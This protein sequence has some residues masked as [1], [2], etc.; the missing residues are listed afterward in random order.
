[1]WRRGVGEGALLEI[2]V[3]D[4]SIFPSDCWRQYSGAGNWRVRS[5][6]NT[7]INNWWENHKCVYG[8]RS[9]WE[10][11]ITV[12]EKIKRSGERFVHD[13]RWPLEKCLTT[14]DLRI[15]KKGGRGLAPVQSLTDVAAVEVMD[16][17]GKHER[18]DSEIV[19]PLQL[20]MQKIHNKDC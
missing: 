10:Y 18:R 6:Q 12:L 11:A 14:A 9:H 4:R 7:F 1:M 8:G 15:E 3:G 5:V 17:Q 19:P 16:T 20:Q 2:R 13:S